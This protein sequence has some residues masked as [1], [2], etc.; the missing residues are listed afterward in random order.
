MS[1]VEMQQPSSA[2]S[3][4]R[5]FGNPVLSGMLACAYMGDGKHPEIAGEGQLRASS[6]S[7]TR[8]VQTTERKRPIQSF[9]RRIRKSIMGRIEAALRG[10][11]EKRVRV[12]IEGT[13]LPRDVSQMRDQLDAV[14]A[15]LAQVAQLIDRVLERQ[16]RDHESLSR[17]L[18]PL[19][20]GL[21]AARNRYGY[22]VLLQDDMPLLGYLVEGSIQEAAVSVVERLLGT[23]DR[24]LD[25]GANVGLFTLVAARRVGPT[26]AV[27]AL[28]PA[29]ATVKALQLT[30][31]LN[32]IAALVDIRGIGCGAKHEK[33][34]LHLAR[35]CGHNSL[36]VFSD[37]MSSIEV[38]VV[39]LDS[40]TP[41]GS[42]WSL[43]KIDVE[44][45]ELEALAGMRRIIADNPN[46]P[47]IIEFSPSH[48][49]AAGNSIQGW[50]Q[51]IGAYGFTAYEIH[52][53][54]PRI[55][56]LRISGLEK[57]DCMD[58]LLVNQREGRIA[59][60]LAEHSL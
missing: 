6:G 59:N 46:M 20:D 55:R 19:G 29:P 11:I 37:A 30:A 5:G 43:A 45:F 21:L 50:L 52:E 60:L 40:V 42:R 1:T 25:L 9:I 2:F 18:I 28:E 47:I 26:G 48:I 39:P 44:G 31:A 33:R 24:F 12:A 16:I 51:R 35:T 10:A 22:L 7:S 13:T 58:L 15:K 34:Q 36:V 49:A 53:E 23:G 54:L 56:R 32:Q 3:T 4:P 17:F 57:V 27:L 8:A 14:N 41:A 38:E